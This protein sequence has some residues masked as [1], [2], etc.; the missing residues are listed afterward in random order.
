M[1]STTR[2]AAARRSRTQPATSGRRPAATPHTL[3]PMSLRMA[4]AAIDLALIVVVAGLVTAWLAQRVTGVVQV[5]VDDAGAMSVLASPS[6]PVWTGIAVWIVLSALYTVPLMAIWGR[7]IGGWCVGIRAVRI[8]TGGPLGWSASAR[9]W[10]LL[11]GIAGAASF[12]PVV[13]S[14]AWL[15]V[16]VIG[17]SPLWD[18]ARRLRGYADHWCGDVVVRAPW[19]R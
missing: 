5:R 13:G 9:R 10:F 15:L 7:T 16:L 19:H 3:A 8:E 2:P 4:G 14:L 1:A 12:L 18:S 17:L 11:Y 6:L